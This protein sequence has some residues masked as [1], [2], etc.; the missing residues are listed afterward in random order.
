[1]VCR[2]AYV[3][4]LILCQRYAEAQAACQGLIEGADRL[5]LQ[6]ELEWR[7]GGL[8]VGCSWMVACSQVPGTRYGKAAV[9]FGLLRERGLVAPFG[10][11]TVP[12]VVRVACL[13]GKRN[14]CG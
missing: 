3:E 9:R 11:W 14:A 13:Q 8:E 5:Y 1:M 7:Q 6:A 4:G 12:A 2:C 10:L